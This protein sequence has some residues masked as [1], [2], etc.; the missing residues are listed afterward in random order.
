MSEIAE[1]PTLN[2]RANTLP[3]LTKLIQEKVGVPADGMFGMQTARA[4]LK[5]LVGAWPEQQSTSVSPVAPRF[6]TRTEEMLATLEP[7][8]ERKFRPFLAACLA[9]PAVDGIELKAICGRR[10]RSKQRQA[11]VSGRSQASYGYSWHNYGLA[12]DFGCFIGRR[13]LDDP[14]TGD[15]KRASA[16]YRAM[17]ALAAGHGIEWGGSW[18]WWQDEPHFQID[19]G[20]STPAPSDLAAL[21]AGTWSFA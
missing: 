20:R 17:G 13:Y 4:V 19:L 10:D 8:A 12:L 6:D 1:T 11:Q 16:V 3:V 2:I 9:L 5:S 7:G 14:E 18:K 21:A 15:P